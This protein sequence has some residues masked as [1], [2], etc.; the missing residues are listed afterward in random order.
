MRSSVASP[1]RSH[2]QR[3]GR[4]SRAAQ[5]APPVDGPVLA[6]LPG[7]ARGDRLGALLM[8]AMPQRIERPAAIDPVGATPPAPTGGPLLQRLKTERERG[9]K[10]RL[11]T[12]AKET[13]ALLG[14]NLLAHVDGHMFRG[15]PLNG[16]PID[17]ADPQGLHAY[18]DGA[19][20]H[21]VVVTGRTGSLNAIHQITWHWAGQAA[22]TA[23]PST[24]FPRWMPAR[25]VR[26]LI[27]LR[28]PDTRNHPIDEDRLSAAEARTWI[29]R[30]QGV[31]TVDKIGNGIN[32]TY[33]PRYV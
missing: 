7:A 8:R 12:K 19:L 20:P 14:D 6:R 32:T 30:T 21:N 27:A 29:A 28:F 3:S 1:L 4:S 2:A 31:I 13:V 10:A 9:D 15:I 25:D 26:T 22:S 23:K 11:R 5:A 24:M 18:T 33:I 17:P 16:G